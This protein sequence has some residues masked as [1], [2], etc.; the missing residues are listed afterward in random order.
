MNSSTNGVR[1][2][3]DTR[4]LNNRVH[5]SMEG[6]S[7]IEKIS[8]FT[9]AV[10]RVT[11][12]RG[13]AILIALPSHDSSQPPQSQQ[14]SNTHENPGVLLTTSF[15]FPTR[16]EAQGA[17]VTFLEQ[18][19]A[20][21]FARLGRRVPPVTAG[22][23][24][25]KVFVCSTS[26]AAPRRAARAAEPTFSAATMR[27]NRR[28]FA[29]NRE[30]L[31]HADYGD[32]ML[33]GASDDEMY[34]Y[35]Y[36]EEEEEREEEEEDADEEELGYTLTLCDLKPLEE[37][38]QGHASQ[39]TLPP[40]HGAS[41]SPFSTSLPPLDHS[42][43]VGSVTSGCSTAAGGP[44]R[45]VNTVNTSNS[46]S[47]G[48]K[49]PIKPLPLPL[50]LSRIA[51]VRVGDHHLMITH[52]NGTERHYVVQTVKKVGKDSCEY[53]FFDPSSEF[54]SGGPIFD[55]RGDFVGVQHQCG[56]HSYGIFISSIVRH[57]FHLNVLGICR[58]P[59]VDVRSDVEGNFDMG[60]AVPD[61]V[62]NQPFH[63]NQRYC[64]L[65]VGAGDQL[66]EYE[67]FKRL[68]LRNNIHGS[69]QPPSLVA[70]ESIAVWRE[71]YTDFGSLV[72]ILHAFSHSPKVVKLAL[73]EMTSHE[74]RLHLSS[75]AS[76]GG[77]GVILEIIDGYPHNEEIVLA[78]LTVLARTSLYNSNREAI[79]RC[80]G[81]L[82]VLEI[83]NEYSHQAYIQQ[84]G[85][86]CLYNLMSEDSPIR[87][88]TT[89]LF[90][91]TQGIAIA[92]E[93]LSTHRNDRHV[94]R[95]ASFTLACVVKNNVRYV[96]EMVSGGII[97]II[98]NRMKEHSDDN[99]I[100]MGLANLL[101]ELLRH[102]VSEEEEE[103]EG[104]EKEEEEREEREREEQQQEEEEE[105]NEDALPL[106]DT[107]SIL[108]KP[109]MDI[110]ENGTTTTDA[111]PH[112]S[113]TRSLLLG[114]S[115]NR[116][117]DSMWG[118]ELLNELVDAQL[119]TVL[120]DVMSREAQE[121]YSS[122][123]VTLLEECIAS[124]L[125]LLQC[126]L[127]ELREELSTVKL[128]ETCQT[129]MCNFPTEKVLMR[130]CT[131]VLRLLTFLL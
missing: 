2:V 111:I 57:L 88:E 31:L 105:K 48:L 61:E 85:F 32:S 95:Y 107:P 82:T 5:R 37:V 91:C 18:P 106:L 124:V 98:V 108:Y 103:G 122:A 104:E 127:T 1:V 3:H 55:M 29:M 90:I 40:L 99:F 42:Y 79:Y 69:T 10:C 28:M 126:R 36:E 63:I 46:S 81:V 9:H 13:T 41:A 58:L 6:W 43:T 19:V 75:V 12:G 52:I 118:C 94:L 30:N 114:E 21:T 97:E 47:N 120:C 123:A 115:N 77:I 89:H 25:D 130:R 54:S 11:D 102:V 131:K 27:E 70:P 119:I 113:A 56:D 66:I 60:A 34:E 80:D 116:S 7:I 15:V 92:M 93:A 110:F 16:E 38:W 101:L 121:T 112:S 65:N 62:F 4:V 83:M 84:W 86:C 129:I 49:L 14:T 76:L 68:R 51:P 71:F 87:V 26:Q 23:R 78:A 67:D 73:E 117:L 53:E 20:G 50:L 96:P 8:D 35:E 64:V 59:I 100:F 33:S 109:E 128:T 125:V 44:V 22:V 17:T 72:L 74:H 45:T 39:S 24:V